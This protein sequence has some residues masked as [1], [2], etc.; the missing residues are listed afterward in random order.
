MSGRSV[1]KK[2]AKGRN[3]NFEL[4][5]IICMLLIIMH[6]LALH[7][8]HDFGEYIY[9]ELSVRELLLGG[10]IGVN[11]FVM[12]SGYFLAGSSFKLKKIAKPY[13]Q[14]FFWS[15]ICLIFVYS[16]GYIEPEYKTTLSSLVPFTFGSYWFA[17]TYL[18]LCILAPFINTLI[19]NISKRQYQGLL[20]F[21]TVLWCVSYTSVC[22]KP[23][24]SEVGW[25]IFIYMIAAYIR[26]Y[27]SAFT[28]KCLLNFVLAAVCLI[29]AGFLMYADLMWNFRIGFIY[30]D[31]NFKTLYQENYLPIFFASIFIFLGF[32]NLKLGCIK[33]INLIA[34]ASFGVYLIHDNKLISDILWNQWIVTIQYSDSIAF[35]YGIFWAVVIYAVCAVLDMVRL[36]LF[37]KPV[38]YIWDRIEDKF[39]NKYVK[40]HITE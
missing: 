19:R 37:E 8:Q 6:H 13:L 24:F 18:I 11:C 22:R 28:E 36:F 10:K 34:T 9:A 33:P 2:S 1:I 38:F 31:S 39:K 15:A 23:G 30:E 7:G 17:T 35:G 3:S 26:L 5:R 16:T 12:I 20:V 14:V 40:K 21:L 32:K 4:L 27:P 25:F 29:I